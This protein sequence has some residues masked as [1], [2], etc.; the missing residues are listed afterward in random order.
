MPYSGFDYLPDRHPWGNYR[1]PLCGWDMVPVRE[2]R[3][4]L[5]QSMEIVSCTNPYC[6][7]NQD[8]PAWRS[9]P[10]YNRGLMEVMPGGRKRVRRD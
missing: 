6:E 4:S 1:C 9:Q 8:H 3:N 5:G 7:L 2:Y 10:A